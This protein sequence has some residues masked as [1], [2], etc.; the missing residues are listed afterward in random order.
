MKLYL[1]GGYRTEFNLV[2]KENNTK[3][4]RNQP[5]QSVLNVKENDN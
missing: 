4:S 5:A 3:E 2:V 1:F